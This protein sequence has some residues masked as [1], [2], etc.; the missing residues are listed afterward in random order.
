MSRTLLEMARASF[1]TM[2]YSIFLCRSGGYGMCNDDDHMHVSIR[3]RISMNVANNTTY[4]LRVPSPHPPFYLH[5][6]AHP[7]PRPTLCFGLLLP[8]DAAPPPLPTTTTTIYSP[9]LV[10]VCFPGGTDMGSVHRTTR[11]KKRKKLSLEC[12]RSEHTERI[13]RYA[14]SF[15]PCSLSVLSFLICYT[16]RADVSTSCA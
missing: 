1:W 15:I 3:T 14:I 12:S 13:S 16:R 11:K 10:G 4:K 9:W 8:T 6:S 2:R 7:H 5:I